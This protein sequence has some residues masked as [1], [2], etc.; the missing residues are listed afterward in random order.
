MLSDTDRAILDVAG[1][2][3]R[4]RGALEAAVR[5]GLGL[6]YTRYLQRLNSLLDDPDALAYAPQT[7]YRLRRITGR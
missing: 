6:T 5:D 7:V 4:Q 3:Y 2:R 1:R